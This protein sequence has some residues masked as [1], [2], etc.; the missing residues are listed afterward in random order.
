[1][2]RTSVDLPEPDRPITTNT[3]PSGTSK[4]T[5]RTAATQPVRASSSARGR[6]ASARVDDALGVR[7]EHLP[8][9]AARDR[10]CRCSRRRRRGHARAPAELVDDRGH[11]LVQVADH[12]V[13]GLGDHGRVGI[14]VDR[15][16]VLRGLH[17]HPVLYGAGDPARDVEVG[18]DA[19]AGLADLVGVRP[20]ALVGHDPRAA[21]RR[22]RAARRAPR[23]RRSPL[24]TRRRARRSRRPARS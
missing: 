18:R 20:P 17:T 24:P 13:V 6:S 5:S 9:P 12:R 10:R 21:D 23:S 2:Q 3:S 11:D 8:H 15:Q 4:L 22:A 1:M 14:G 7:P 16:H 19:L